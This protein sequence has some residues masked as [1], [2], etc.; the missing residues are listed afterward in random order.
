MSAPPVSSVPTSSPP[1]GSTSPP[2]AGGG[3]P[4]RP[5]GLAE[6]LAVALDSLDRWRDVGLGSDRRLV[7]TVL[8]VVVVGALVGGTLWLSTLDD[9]GLPV[10]DLLPRAS[11]QAV[12]STVHESTI[13]DEAVDDAGGGESIIVHVVGAVHRPGLVELAAGERVSDA[14]ER[15]G[16]PTDQA[17]IHL[18]NLAALVSDGMQIEVPAIG[19]DQT[20]PLIRGGEPV[21]EEG[22][23]Q[24]GPVDINRAT[25]AELETL[26]GIGPATAAAIIAHRDGSGPFATPEDLLAVRGIGEAKLE[27]LR[28]L[29]VT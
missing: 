15:A 13:D 2:P 3:E 26:P 1:A 29:V 23:A 5:P 18:L 28:D 22:A 19:A 14:V 17:D 10:D 9:S 25:A 4:D 7:R 21:A 8:A 20:G 27:A 24:S 11:E 12:P 16:G 6:G